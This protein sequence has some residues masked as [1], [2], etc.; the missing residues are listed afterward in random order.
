M[1]RLQVDS[2]L[3]L[4]SSTANIFGNWINSMDKRFKILI[5]VGALVIFGHLSYIELIRFLLIKIISNVG[6]QP[7]Q[8]FAPF[9]VVSRAM[10]N[11]YP[12]YEGV[13]EYNEKYF[14]PHV[15]LRD[16][17]IDLHR[18]RR[19]CSFYEDYLSLSKI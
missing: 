15:W 5:R 13:R 3:Y 8:N 17:R 14:Y 2:T 18:H 11:H 4:P 10:E 1:A 19:F 6:Y 7:V 9:M 12:V 16:I